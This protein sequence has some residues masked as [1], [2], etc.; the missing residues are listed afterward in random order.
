[1]PIWFIFWVWDLQLKEFDLDLCS[2]FRLPV[3]KSL[4]PD[5]RREDGAVRYAKAAAPQKIL[6]RQHPLEGYDLHR[7]QHCSGDFLHGRN[8]DISVE[9]PFSQNLGKKG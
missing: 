7:W 9:C 6:S 2:R 8:H 5:E 3:M 1:M 4:P